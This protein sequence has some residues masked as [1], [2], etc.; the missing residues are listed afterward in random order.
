M[1]YMLLAVI[2]SSQVPSTYSRLTNAS[3]RLTNRRIF[4]PTPTPTPAHANDL[5]RIAA[6]IKE[7]EDDVRAILDENTQVE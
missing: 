2:M 5:H 7:L 3:A 4:P 6:K 1:E